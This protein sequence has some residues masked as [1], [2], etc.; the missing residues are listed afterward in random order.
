MTLEEK[1]G[2]LSQYV[3]DQPEWTPAVDKG[4]AGSILN[5]GGA[6]QVNQLQR[7]TL[8]GSRL[9]IPLLIGHDVIHGYRT[10]FPIPLAIASSWSPE[11]AT[12]SAH[13]A[14]KEARAAGIRWTFAPMVDVARDP[15]WGRI[16]EGAGE[17]PFLGSAMARAY[18][19]GFQGKDLKASDSLLACAKHFAAYGAAEGGR[20]YGTTD[21]S[22]T[23]LRE[24]YLPPF[25]AAAEAGVASFMSAFNSLNGVPSTANRHLLREI[26]RNE[27]K[28]R[29]VVVSDWAAVTQLIDHGLAATPADAA[30][31]ALNAGVDMDMWDH[32]YGELVPAIRAGRLRSSVVDDSV[33]RILR[34]KFDSGLFD[35]PF[36]DETKMAAA[37]LTAENRAA[38]RR[39][40][41]RSIVLLK[42]EGDLLPLSPSARTIAVIGPLADSKRDM[43]GPWAAQGKAEDTVSM[44]E[45]LRAATRVTNRRE[46]P[47]AQ[48]ACAWYSRTP[49]RHSA[50]P[51]CAGVRAKWWRRHGQDGARSAAYPRPAHAEEQSPRARRN[52]D[53]APT[54]VLT[55]S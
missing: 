22:E 16:A 6:A 30:F 49:C 25:R 47:P 40:A 8:A 32:A 12:L 5:S 53:T 55:K 36:T 17:D 3:P 31:L 11:L 51:R 28:F 23:R 10:I 20:D 21:M 54:R 18:V 19:V 26:L 46:R 34:A 37:M 27:W 9:R 1:L 7:R 42:N 4:L 38:A 14:A 2:Q 13:V 45:G 15:R 29:G 52:W 35:A 44:I 41:Q 33:R 50:W 39:I 24:T 48:R 43:L